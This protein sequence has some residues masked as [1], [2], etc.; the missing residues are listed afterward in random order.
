M[1][2]V[3]VSEQ[4]SHRLFISRVKVLCLCPLYGFDQKFIGTVYVQVYV[5]YKY[6]CVGTVYKYMDFVVKVGFFFFAF[7]KTR[8]D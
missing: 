2:L 4:G 5:L 6:K 8:S 7:Y 3:H 1:F